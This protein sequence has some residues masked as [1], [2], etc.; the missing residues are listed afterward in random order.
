MFVTA[1]RHKPSVQ[2]LECSSST[3][4]PKPRGSHPSTCSGTPIIVLVQKLVP[5][6][7]IIQKFCDQL[8][9]EWL[10]VC[11]YKLWACFIIIEFKIVL[12]FVKCLC[13]FR[14]T[15][16]QRCGDKL[17]IRNLISVGGQ[18]QGV[19]GFPR[20]PGTNLTLCDMVRKMLNIGA[21]EKLIQSV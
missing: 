5:C 17:K 1:S 20:C 12:V 18:H 11:G 13:I 15:V 21:Y 6:L 10:C 8:Y 16:V 4:N 3:T 19:F 9:L 2:S 7:C 14:R